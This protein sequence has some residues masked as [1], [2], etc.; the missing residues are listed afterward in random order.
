MELLDSTQI[1]G[2]K[3]Q[4][5]NSCKNWHVGKLIVFTMSVFKL[6]V[7]TIS[8]VISTEYGSP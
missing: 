8:D 7:F 3:N 5:F 2:G 1:F 4:K 6:L